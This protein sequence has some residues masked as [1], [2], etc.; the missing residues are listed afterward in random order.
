MGKSL[1][2]SSA[3]GANCRGD[4]ITEINVALSFGNRNSWLLSLAVSSEAQ[5]W[6]GFSATSKRAELGLKVIL[7]RELRKERAF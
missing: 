3:M 5:R 1:G 7:A 4:V 6:L 2:I